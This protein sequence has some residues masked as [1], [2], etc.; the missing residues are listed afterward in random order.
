MIIGK[1]FIVPAPP[2]PNKILDK[3]TWKVIK[4]VSDQ[5]IYLFFTNKIF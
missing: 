1:A 3:N 4:K 5:I 2:E